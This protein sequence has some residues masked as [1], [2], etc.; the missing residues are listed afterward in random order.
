MQGVFAPQRPAPGLGT[1]WNSVL[2]PGIDDKAERARQEQEALRRRTRELNAAR[3]GAQPQPR[4]PPIQIIPPPVRFTIKGRMYYVLRD[5]PDAAPRPGALGHYLVPVTVDTASGRAS[6]FPPPEDDDAPAPAP[7]APAQPLP[8]APNGAPSR[9][10]P[11]TRKC[12]EGRDYVCVRRGSTEYWEVGLRCLQKTL[13]DAEALDL[14][15][16]RRMEGLS[17]VAPTVVWD[18]IDPE[19]DVSDREAVL[20]QFITKYMEK[21]YGGLD[22]GTAPDV[23]AVS[24]EAVHKHKEFCKAWTARHYRTLTPAVT[25]PAESMASE[26]Y[27]HLIP[28]S[29]R[30]DEVRLTRMELARILMRHDEFAPEF[31]SALH[32]FT[33]NLEQ[34]RGAR[35]AN[36]KQMRMMSAARVTSYAS[37][38]QLL[39][40]KESILRAALRTVTKD[41]TARQ[42]NRLTVDW[43]AILGQVPPVH[44]HFEDTSPWTG[45][46]EA[47][48][49]AA[50]GRVPPWRFGRES[51]RP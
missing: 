27:P 14:A 39:A 38:G 49:A 44:R 21:F 4:A 42:L 1:D 28:D 10:P 16:A 12:Q 23:A 46:S 18:C 31:A 20:G 40:N 30:E 25:A 13:E 45:L 22:G 51:N 2:D 15:F 36:Y 24:A 6:P 34:T 26:F 29:A 8:P 9:P 43:H 7:A 19:Y 41:E 17:N 35:N 50:E 3:D 47:R 32:Y 48:R 37:L 5:E 33:T 11:D